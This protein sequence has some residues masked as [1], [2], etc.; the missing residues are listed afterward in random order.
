L[1]LRVSLGDIDDD[2]VWSQLELGDG[3]VVAEAVVDADDDA[4]AEDVSI[5]VEMLRI[6]MRSVLV[7]AWRPKMTVNPRKLPTVAPSPALRSH[8]L[9]K[10]L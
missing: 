1:R 3:A 9:M 10:C 8:D 4:E 2:A 5:V 7:E 6:S